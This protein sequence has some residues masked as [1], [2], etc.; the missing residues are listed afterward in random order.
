MPEYTL[1]LKPCT[2]DTSHLTPRK[3]HRVGGNSMKSHGAE[4]HRHRQFAAASKAMVILHYPTAAVPDP[5]TV[6]PRP[7]PPVSILWEMP[8]FTT[9]HYALLSTRGDL[10]R[11]SCKAYGS[12][13]VFCGF[14]AESC[15]VSPIANPYCRYIEGPISCQQRSC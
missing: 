2:T 11:V 6:P 3:A 1:S 15:Q 9:N 7:P 8:P 5:A 10:R 4:V 13:L 12:A 14:S